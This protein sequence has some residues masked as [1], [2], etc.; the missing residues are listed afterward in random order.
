MSDSTTKFPDFTHDAR[1][2]WEKIPNCAQKRILDAVWCGHCLG[3]V[4]IELPEGRLKRGFLILKGTCKNCGSVK[5]GT[6]AYFCRKVCT[7]GLL[8]NM[9]GGSLVRHRRMK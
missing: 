3:G 7:A 4:P 5:P 6:A 9:V 8:K 1:A 2:R